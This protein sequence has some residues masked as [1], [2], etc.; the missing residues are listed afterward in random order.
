MSGKR[1]RG[2]RGGKGGSSTTS[3]AAELAEQLRTLESDP[4]K[5]HG[6]SITRCSRT[7]HVSLAKKQRPAPHHS[8][9]PR[10][11]YGLGE[12]KDG[13]WAKKPPQLAA[14]GQDP[15]ER[16][17]Q[18]MRPLGK[19]AADED[20]AADSGAAAVEHR[21]LPVGLR[22]LG[23]T[24]YLNAQMQCLFHLLPFRRAVYESQLDTIADLRHR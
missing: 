7:D 21:L 20:A 24:C 3:R 12:G 5:L 1:K 18:C 14:L 10:C 15:V 22:N 11:L 6:A 4:Y 23:A 8:A 9:N 17:R 13:I 16:Y 19:A 2:G